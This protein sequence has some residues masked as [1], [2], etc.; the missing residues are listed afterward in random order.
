M[1]AFGLWTNFITCTR[2]NSDESDFLGLCQEFSCFLIFI[3]LFSYFIAL[4]IYLFYHNF[5]FFFCNRHFWFYEEDKKTTLKFT[6]QFT[7]YHYML[8]FVQN[9]DF[10]LLYIFW[11]SRLGLP[12]T[13]TAFV[14]RGKNPPQKRCPG[15]DTK[16]SDD[17]VPVMQEIWGIRYTPSLPSLPRP[18]TRSGNTW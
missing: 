14:Q 10:S 7:F 2:N 16:Q 4:F 3:F 12:N 11:P 13:P 1:I 9:N 6:N 17:E 15:Y 5:F 18:L 8:I